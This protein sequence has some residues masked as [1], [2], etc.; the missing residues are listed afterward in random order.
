MA[1]FARSINEK[2]AAWKASES[3]KPLVI[4]GARQVGKT[5]ALKSFAAR[6]FESLAYIDFSRDSDVASIFDGP[7]SPAQ[8]VSNLSVYLHMDIEPEKT[9]IVFDEVQLCERALTSLKYFCDE[10]PE[11]CVASAG[12]LLGV[13]IHREN[14]S[15]PVGKVDILNLHP[16]N[17]EEYLLARGEARLAEAVRE[18]YGSP[19]AAFPLHDR[20]MSL[21]KEYE[22]IGGMPEVVAEFVGAGASG[23]NALELAQK[24]QAE[25]CV[26]Y[27]ADMV[28]YADEQ[29]APRILAAWNSL[30]RQLAKENHKF[31]YKEIRS[32]ARAAQY[33]TALEWLAAAGIAERCLRVTDAVAPLA[34]FAEDANFKLYGADTGLLSSR[35]E[36][37]PED[38]EPAD[39]KASRFRGAIAE[40]YVFQ[41]L[42]SSDAAVYYWGTASRYE[43]EFVARKKTGEVVPIEVK[44][45]KNVRSKSLREFAERYGIEKAYRLSSR[46]FGEEAGVVS[47]PLYAAWL[48]GEEL[49]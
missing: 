31:Q 30:P 22:L 28:K 18:A 20:A 7:I 1:D 8:L 6:E 43:V 49:R 3:R 29:D 39:N 45:G 44:S 47:V 38:L 10:G 12:S 14:Y 37:R 25:I 2:L 24:K 16:M 13:Q 21:V 23:N 9:L 42:R 15:F 33:Q 17:F 40:N 46:N 48:L 26:A 19:N 11:Y 5:Y 41:Q 27:A 35:F 34:T 36:A 4:L 32:G